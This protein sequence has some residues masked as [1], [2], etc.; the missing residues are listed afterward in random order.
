MAL[1]DL[2]GRRWALR[3]LWEL[4][5]E[6]LVFRA[7]QARCDAMSPSVL[8]LRLTELR[9]AGIVE[10]QHGGGYRLTSEGVALLDALAPL[11]GWATRWARRT[12][13]ARDARSSAS[14]RARRSVP[15]RARASTPRAAVRA[16]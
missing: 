15:R 4:R 12:P 6:P 10:L 16:R 8:S 11:Q 2:L 13:A 1:L 9:A 14:R 7:V 5:A 3:V